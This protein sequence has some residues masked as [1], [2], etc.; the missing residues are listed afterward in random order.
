MLADLMLLRKLPPWR[1]NLGKRLVKSPKLYVRDSGLL[2][3]LLGLGSHDA[4]LAHPV[5]GNSWEGFAIETLLNAAPRTSQHGFY[6][7]S[8]GAEIDLLLDIPGHGLIAIEIKKGPGAKPRRGFYAACEDLQPSH[9]YVVHSGPE[10][11]AYPVGEGV[12]AIGLRTLLAQLAGLK[13]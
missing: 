1:S 3:A 2:H 5:V 10:P 12:Q 8:N 13:P 4:L 11:Q 9:R 7:T 6:R